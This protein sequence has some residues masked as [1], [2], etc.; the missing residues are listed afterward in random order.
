MPVREVGEQ[1]AMSAWTSI[2][3]SSSAGNVLRASG[4]AIGA[5]RNL[6]LCFCMEAQLYRPGIGPVRHSRAKAQ[7][8][9]G[10]VFLGGSLTYG[11]PAI[12]SAH[13]LDVLGIRTVLQIPAPRDRAAA[14]DLTLPLVR[15]VSKSRRFSNLHGPGTTGTS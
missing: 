11:T 7:L 1:A 14:Q 6:K 2:G 12:R 13:D 3:V 15:V 10:C 9:V 8:F 4:V 5:S